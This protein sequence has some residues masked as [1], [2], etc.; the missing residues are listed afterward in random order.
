MSPPMRIPTTAASQKLLVTESTIAPATA[1]PM[2]CPS[3]AML[4]TP[5]RSQSTP[6]SEP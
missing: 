2:N 1:P 6:E 4:T 3:M 5:E